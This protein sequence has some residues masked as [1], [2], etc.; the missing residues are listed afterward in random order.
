MDPQTVSLL[1]SI[2]RASAT[3]GIAESGLCVR[4]LNDPNFSR[5]LRD[6]GGS[7]TGRTVQ[8]FHLYIADNCPE[9]WVREI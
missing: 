5:R 9:A 7:C 1:D 4:V 8:K 2:A 6:R 3:L